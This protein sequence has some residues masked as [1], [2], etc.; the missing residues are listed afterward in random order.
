[1]NH[2]FTPEEENNQ[3]DDVLE[4]LPGAGKLLLISLARIRRGLALPQPFIQEHP[5]AS[6][7]LEPAVEQLQYYCVQQ[8]QLATQS[9]QRSAY[10]FLIQHIAEM[11]PDTH[12]LHVTLGA[13]A[14]LRQTQAQQLRRTG[15]APSLAEELEVAAQICE[16]LVAQLHRAE[17]A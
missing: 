8:R 10:D 9:H 7:S 16:A 2:S 4:T 15:Y 3:D 6:A 5:S 13:W 12:E 1:M 11:R 14:R 17:Q